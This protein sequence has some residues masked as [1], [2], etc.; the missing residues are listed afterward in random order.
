MQRIQNKRASSLKEW[1]VYITRV[2][3]CCPQAYLLQLSRVDKE[4][5][6]KERLVQSVLKEAD[7][8]GKDGERCRYCLTRVVPR[9]F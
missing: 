4:R 3:V 8:E 6:S 9:L 1:V 7:E 5:R 2:L